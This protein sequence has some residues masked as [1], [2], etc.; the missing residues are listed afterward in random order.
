MRRRARGG[1]LWGGVLACMVLISQP[2]L[3][4]CGN[5]ARY[6]DVLGCYASTSSN[7]YCITL[8]CDFQDPEMTLPQ[9]GI[10]CYDELSCA[11]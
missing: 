9:E 8:R 2:V 3:A 11:I 1:F 4:L 6:G 7:N 5:C 10:C